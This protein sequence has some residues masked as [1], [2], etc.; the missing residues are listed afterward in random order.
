MRHRALDLY[1]SAA[2]REMFVNRIRNERTLTNVES[3]LRRKDGS[4]IWVLENVTLINDDSGAPMIQGTMIDIT[5]RKF[6]EQ[7]LR[8]AEGRYRSIFENAAEGIFQIGLDGRW[9]I[10]N[11][12]LAHILGYDSAEQLTRSLDMK[13]NYYADPERRR[14]FIRLMQAHG[15]ISGFESLVYRKDGQTIWISESGRCVRNE[16]GHLV[17]FEGTV[18]DITERRRAEESLRQ[19][20][21]RLRLQNEV[22]VELSQLK[23]IERGDLSP[24]LRA[25]TEAAAYTLEVEY[26]SVWIFDAERTGLHC[27]DMF[28]QSTRSH[29][30]GKEY[31]VLEYPAYFQALDEQRTIDADDAQVDSRTSELAPILAQQGITSVMDSGIRVG[32]NVVGVLSL[33]HT[34]PARGWTLDE[35]N[36]AGAI[37]DLVSLAIEASGRK[38]AQDALRESESKFRAVAETAASAIY[39]HQGQRFLFTNKASESISG[40]NRDDLMAMD[41][42]LLVHPEDR[43]FVRQRFEARFKGLPGQPE[44]YEFRI[45]TKAGETRWLDFSAG[46]IQFEGQTALLGTAFDITERKRGEQLQSALYRIAEKTSTARG[47]EEFFFGIHSILSELIYARNIYIALYDPRSQLLSFPYHVDEHD[48]APAPRK[49]LKGLTEYVLRTGEPYLDSPERERELAAQGEME[50]IGSPS[51]AWIGVP[52]KSGDSTF[53]VLALQ[54]YTEQEKFGER[55]IE[56]LTFVSRSV[57]TAIQRKK[58]EELLRKSEERY[59][60]QVQSAVYGIYRSQNESRFLDVNPALVTML[61]YERPEE[62]LA[63]DMATQVYADPSERVRLLA[64]HK[65]EQQIAGVEVQWKG[66]NNKLITVRLSGRALLNEQGEAE[67]FE[68]LAEDVTERRMLEEQLRQSQKMEAV[69]RLAGGVAHDFNNLLTVIKGYSEL[70]L[71]QIQPSDPMRAEVE[72]VKRAADRAA[73][74]TRQLLAFSR[75]QVLAPKVL[76]MNVVVT[77]MEKLLRRLLGEDVELVCN[78]D[79]A[80]G[81]TKADPGQ[82]EQ[83]V[84]NLAVNARDAMPG[85][86]RLIISTANITLEHSMPEGPSAGPYIRLDVADTGTGMDAQTCSRIFEPFFTTKEQGKGTG[87]GLST[88]YGIV[89]QSGGFID[90]QSEP[91]KGTIFSILLPRVDE[92]AAAA[93]P[94]TAPSTRRSGTETILLVEDED[95]VRALARQLLQKQGYTVLDARH[96]GEALLVCERHSEPIHL[97]LTDVVLAQMSGRE[98]AQRLLQL[99][100]EMKVLFMSGYSGDAVAQ[101]G[102]GELG[103]AF[104]QK[105]FNTESLITKV[106]ETLDA[107]L[108]KAVEQ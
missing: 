22:L 51:V 14:E 3:L 1:Q 10:A 105:P 72:E 53:G 49:L 60:S 80:L 108:A 102:I 67:S 42:F 48:V 63:L 83:V 87:L 45:V 98:L 19:S 69:G 32:G 13:T 52:L 47:L 12:K 34:G 11:P 8:Q 90:V 41:P 96:A 25:I 65:P 103:E 58:D 99:R 33:E 77:N 54:S 55:D 37:A 81:R 75:K 17:G 94:S 4:P 9:I 97:L 56:I 71:D 44:R 36:F 107:P 28:S 38:R 2:D 20:E 82:T 39:V 73:A 15:S 50:L 43:D 76:D 91:G 40:Y 7:S 93:A 46:M 27:V 104:L 61:G 79:T 85:G 29:Q 92:A 64:D 100:P 24:A 5:E 35:K 57:A 101:H 89:K 86:G 70:M 23:T 78:L 21:R 18:Q 66:K 88:V 16:Y 59:R 62:V 106:R 74:L 84:M 6:A 95:G 26:V 31:R 68:M 30:S